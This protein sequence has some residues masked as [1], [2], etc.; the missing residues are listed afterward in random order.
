M[1]AWHLETVRSCTVYTVVQGRQS[2]R[3]SG[4]LTELCECIPARWLP[5]VVKADQT[6][7]VTSALQ[8]RKQDPSI[9]GSTKWMCCPKTC[10]LIRQRA[11]KVR[12]P[13]FLFHYTKVAKW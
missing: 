13:T 5:V 7:A 12:E 9:K 8:Q 2:L 4:Q 3:S 6:D 10:K 1:S 11:K